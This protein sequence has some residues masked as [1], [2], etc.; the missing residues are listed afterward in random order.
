MI[1]RAF[2]AV[3]SISDPEPELPQHCGRGFVADFDGGDEAREHQI[4]KR[5][6]DERAATLGGQPAV[7]VRLREVERDRALTFDRPAGFEMWIDAAI[8]DVRAVLFE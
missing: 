8:A 4:A 7:P 1:E 6:V 2:L 5:E 3:L